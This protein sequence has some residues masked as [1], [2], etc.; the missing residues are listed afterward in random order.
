M[1]GYCRRF[2]VL[3]R[4]F[5]YKGNGV[6]FGFWVRGKEVV[7]KYEMAGKWGEHKQPTVY[8]I[9]KEYDL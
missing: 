1:V 4:N 8:E 9:C 5:H 7:E 6:F 3:I 2:N